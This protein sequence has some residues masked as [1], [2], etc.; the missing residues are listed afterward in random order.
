MLIPA[1]PGGPRSQ[2]YEP[3]LLESEREAVADL[4]QYLESKL[5]L[6]DILAISN[7]LRGQ[8]TMSHVAAGR[9]ARAKVFTASY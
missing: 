9:V 7:N 6:S 1:I 8:W 4:L 5:A 2:G 3:L